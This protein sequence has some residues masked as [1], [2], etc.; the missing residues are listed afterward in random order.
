MARPGL[1][2]VIWCLVR[3]LVCSQTVSDGFPRWD[4]GGHQGRAAAV[5]RGGSADCVHSVAQDVPDGTKRVV[6]QFAGGLSDL[7]TCL[8]RAGR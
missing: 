7:E 4:I 2:V 8:T 1:M 3:E 5:G 6:L